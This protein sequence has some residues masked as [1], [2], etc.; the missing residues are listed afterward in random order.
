MHLSTKM[1][2]SIYVYIYVCIYNGFLYACMYVLMY[3]CMYVFDSNDNHIP[4][5]TVATGTPRGIWT[6]DSS[7]S[8][9]F[10]FELF[11][12]TPITDRL[13]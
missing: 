3:V 6:M 8:S 7:E 11:T 5:A 10:K 1:Q 12:G 9:P 2:A 13:G 4:M